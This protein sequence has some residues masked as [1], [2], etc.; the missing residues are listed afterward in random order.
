[1]QG[2]ISEVD[3]VREMQRAPADAILMRGNRPLTRKVIEAGSSLRVISKQCAGVDS[4]DLAAAAERGVMVT[5]TG[6]DC[7]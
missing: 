1:M 7:D 2:P 6:D 4:L 5:T 3:L